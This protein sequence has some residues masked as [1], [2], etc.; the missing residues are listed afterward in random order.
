MNKVKKAYI[1][2]YSLGNYDNNF[3][4]NLFVTFDIEIAKKYVNRFNRIVS[5]YKNFYKRFEYH[6]YPFLKEDSDYV[7]SEDH[8]NLGEEHQKYYD[9]WVHL[10]NFN[11]CYFQKIEIR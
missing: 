1:I 11:N 9:R 10:K 8:Y 2:K 3:I 6:R 4:G 5:E 7:D